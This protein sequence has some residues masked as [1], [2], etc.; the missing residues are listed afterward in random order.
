MFKEPGKDNLARR[1]REKRRLSLPVLAFAGGLVATNVALAL[2]QPASA[3]RQTAKV[4]FENGQRIATVPFDFNDRA[5]VVQ[6]RVNDSQ[7]LKFFF[8]T[9]AG[10]SV[11][12]AAQAAKLGLPQTGK[13]NVIGTGGAVSG[14]FATG[15]SL[16]VQGVTVLNQSVAVFSL[17]DF[18]CEARD[19]AGLIGYDFIKDFVVQIDYEAKVLRLVDRGSFH[20]EGKGVWFPLTIAKTPRVRA[21]IKLPGREAIEGLFEIDTGHEGTMVINSPFVNRHKLLESLAHGIPASGR[22]VGG[23][24]RRIGARVESL[25]LGSYTVPSPVV[26]LSLENTGALSATDN[27]GVIGNEVWQRFKVTL[28]YAGRR[29]WLEPNA[30]LK[31]AFAGDTSGIEIESAGDNCRVF[32]VTSVADNSPAAEAGI[33][34]GDELVAIDDVPAAQFTAAQIYQLFT[35]EGADHSLTIRRA[36][37]SLTVR[38]KLRRLF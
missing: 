13:L 26:A 20:Y 38:I 4:R 36:N 21:R 7:P 16:S 25:Q 17:D 14:T 11:V 30:Y 27:D 37:Q 23:I 31:D 9:G 28:D 6:V 1:R 15:V 33:Q 22:G 29:M 32:K 2:R 18:P 8:D 19:I 12:G 3:E 5:I 34:P 10:M 35:I 24:S